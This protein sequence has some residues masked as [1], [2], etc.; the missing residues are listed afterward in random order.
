MTEKQFIVEDTTYTVAI[1]YFEGGSPG[2]TSGDPGDCYPP[3]DPEVEFEDKVE[4][5]TDEDNEVKTMS[6][7]DF[8]KLYAAEHTEG[9]TDK[10]NDR[11]E[12]E[13]ITD[14]I[15]LAGEYEP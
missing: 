14:I 9:D 10:A 4:Y 6:F 12:D 11:I 3:E 2:R 13:T 7:D 5:A 15:E 8:L 1:S